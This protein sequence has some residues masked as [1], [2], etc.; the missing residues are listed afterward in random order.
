MDDL[1]TFGGPI[2]ASCLAPSG[3]IDS[4]GPPRAPPRAGRSSS[5]DIS[6][7]RR[8]IIAL[9]VVGPLVLGN[10][11]QHLAQALQAFLRV[12]RF[13]E[14]IFRGSV[15]GREIGRHR[16]RAPRAIDGDRPRLL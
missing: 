7:M 2:N 1:P 10:R 11:P 14:R 13:A 16:S 8:L 4:G 6:L 3:G 12:T 5:S 15:V 9:E